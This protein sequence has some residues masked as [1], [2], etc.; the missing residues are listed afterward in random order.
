MGIQL[1]HDSVMG[2]E[3]AFVGVSL[4]NCLLIKLHD[5]Q[6]YAQGFKRLE[7]NFVDSCF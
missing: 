7:N 2:I 5:F 1:D 3:S 6:I 4:L